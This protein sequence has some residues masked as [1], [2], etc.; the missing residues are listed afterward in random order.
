MCVTH[1]PTGTSLPC[2]TPPIQQ[3][4]EQRQEQRQAQRDARGVHVL[5]TAALKK[6]L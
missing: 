6:W 1:P 3:W 5:L 2:M 4:Q